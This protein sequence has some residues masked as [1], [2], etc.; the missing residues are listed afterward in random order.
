MVSRYDERA[1]G[2]N[3]TEQY[4]EMLDEKNLTQITHYFTPKLYH[5]TSEEVATLD[6]IPVEWKLGY[7]YFKLADQYYQDPTKWWIIAWFNQRP[8][9][10]H[11]NIGDTI[12]IPL[13]LDRVL[14]ILK[15]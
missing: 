15:V 4:Q 5:P 6:L 14:K 7:R 12:D 1:I 9:E 11:V 8:T 2:V 3:Q 10:A 13:P